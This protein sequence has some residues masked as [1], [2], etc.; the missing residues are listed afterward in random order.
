MRFDLLVAPDL[1]N[2]LNQARRVGLGS[3]RT[4]AAYLKYAASQGILNKQ[5][6]Y[7]PSSSQIAS[8][9]YELGLTLG[10]DHRV[11]AVNLTIDGADQVLPG[12]IFIKGGGGALLKEKILWSISEVVYVLVTKEKVSEKLTVA[13]PLEVHPMAANSV[14]EK[15]K[16]LNGE[17]R[18]RLLERGYA[19]T[20]ENGNLIVDVI[21]RK[22]RNIARLERELKLIPGVLEVG[23]FV[24]ERAKLYVI[25]D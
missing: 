11:E 14:I 15:I 9:A 10:S 4:V 8:V 2:S 6:S 17:G 18:L 16:R 19:Y 5:A 24:D 3:G 23:I 22:K 20:T 21:F 7:I 25:P 13:V 1:E 12:N